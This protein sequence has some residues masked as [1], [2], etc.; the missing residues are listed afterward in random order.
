MKR[1]ESNESSVK[2]IRRRKQSNLRLSPSAPDV[3]RPHKKMKT[4][5]GTRWLANY[6]ALPVMMRSAQ[7]DGNNN[8]KGALL[9][10][11]RN[12]IR[13]NSRLMSFVIIIFFVFIIVAV[14]SG[15]STFS[16]FFGLCLCLFVCLFKFRQIL[17]ETAAKV[18]CSLLF[19][20][21]DRSIIL[22]V[23]FFSFFV[24]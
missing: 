15:F 21:L 10:R 3:E 1:N 4:R 7:E 24:W 13:M 2:W 9:A 20:T 23:R 17:N 12:C 11:N 19:P 5:A 18:N 14:I 22:F 8:N 6:W 16:C